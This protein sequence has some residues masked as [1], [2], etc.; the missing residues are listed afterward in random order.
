MWRGLTCSQGPIATTGG[1]GTYAFWDKE[2]RNRLKVVCRPSLPPSRPQT[3]TSCPGAYKG[4]PITAGSFSADGSI[5]AFAAGYDWAKGHESAG[6]SKVA[7]FVHAVT[8]EDLTKK[9]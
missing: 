5:Y 1:D 9:T 8:N 6:T 4:Q 7:V 3:T 2:A